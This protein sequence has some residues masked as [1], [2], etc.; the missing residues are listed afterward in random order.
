M[1]LRRQVRTFTFL[2][3]LLTGAQAGPPD[4]RAIRDSLASV[5][6]WQRIRGLAE[7]GLYDDYLAQTCWSPRPDSGLRCVGRWSY[8]PSYK[9]SVHATATDTL[10]LLTR[11]SGATIARF[12]SGDSVTIEPLG[13]IDCYGIPHRAILQD[14]LVCVGVQY[15]G[16]GLEVFGVGTPSSPHRLASVALP[17]VNDIA[18]ADTLIYLACADDTL[19]VYSIADPRAPV[20]I[21]S[22][23]DSSD[24]AMCY[25]DGYCYLVHSTGVNIVDVRDPANPHRAGRIAGH[26]PLAVQ[27]RDSIC[28]LTTENDGF[29]VYDVSD[30]AA[31]MPMGGLS[32]PDAEDLYLPP[33]CDTVAY[34]SYLHIVSIAD[35]SSPR[36]IGQLASPGWDEGVS[37]TPGVDHVLLADYFDGVVVIDVSE[38]TVPTM[39]TMA[40]AAGLAVDISLD[41]GRAYVASQY[42]ALAILDVSDPT[43]PTALGVYDTVGQNPV[44]CGAVVGRDSFAFLAWPRPRV[45]TIDVIDPTRPGRAGGCEEMFSQPED[46][47]L[48]DTLLYCAEASRFQVVN[49]ARPREPV[50]VGSC[51]I[52]DG[53]W[54]LVVQDTLAYVAGVS[55]YIV[56]VADPSNPVVVNTAGKPSIG[57]AVRD[58][59]VYVPSIETLYVYSAA[60]PTQ[61]RVLSTTPTGRAW[62]VVLG[63]SLL[64][65]GTTVGAEAYDVS[66]PAQPRKV[67]EASAPYSN[68][69]LWYSDGYLF[70]ALWD[71]GVAVYETTATGVSEQRPAAACGQVRIR[72]VPSLARSRVRLV[73]TAKVHR[74][75]VYDA[76]GRAVAVGVTA[77]KE[78]DVELNVAGLVPGVYFVE[79]VDSRGVEVLRFAR[80]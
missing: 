13:E 63:D 6:P 76:T 49:V 1:G 70:S 23:C 61:L 50:L 8:G 55:L 54:G 18:E 77:R 51:N 4:W 33:S 79:V 66:N 68:R 7:Q 57:V 59:F 47:V 9:V 45:V 62:D 3:I 75:V 31:P 10:V 39:D 26:A 40:L 24:L 43:L 12:R 28:C 35:P 30:P 78:G 72:V 20:L 71:A 41:G 19:R 58:T 53:V 29:L 69:R 36:L 48:R 74:V 15:G 60:D 65:I 37:A 80:P 56:N 64:F 32:L 5:R 22:C 34:T 21:G 14:T 44:F 38:P 67:A 2:V 46:M 42:S 17:S 27:V 16:A 11:G 73:G 25:A 52:Q